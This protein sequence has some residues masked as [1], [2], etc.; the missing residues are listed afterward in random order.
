MNAGFPVQQVAHV[1]GFAS[2]PVL[3]EGVSRF[4]SGNY[5]PTGPLSPESIPHTLSLPPS[6]LRA[7]DKSM[8]AVSLSP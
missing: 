2:A 6:P 7:H 8:L 1:Q 3:G 5:R 4:P